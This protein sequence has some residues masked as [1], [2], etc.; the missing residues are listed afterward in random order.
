MR[1]HLSIEEQAAPQIGGSMCRIFQVA[2]VVLLV[3]CVFA[4]SANAQEFNV[5]SIRAI[6]ASLSTDLSDPFNKL[7]LANDIRLYFDWRVKI[8]KFGYESESQFQQKFKDAFE[9]FVRT[10][11]SKDLKG[12]ENR[13]NTNILTTMVNA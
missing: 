8:K 4:Y 9:I 2:L 1:L 6:A 12:A 13:L 10:L 11:Y 5:N 7:Q 3:E